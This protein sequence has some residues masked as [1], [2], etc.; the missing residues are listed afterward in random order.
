MLKY[1]GSSFVPGIPARDL[2]DE[3]AELYG[4]ARLL[5]TG[6][7]IA[8]SVGFDEVKPKKIGKKKFKEAVKR[9]D[10]DSSEVNNNGW[11]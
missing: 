10:E 5:G 11:N 2:T 6:L 7:Y 3:E 9:E 4:R 8:T 1:V